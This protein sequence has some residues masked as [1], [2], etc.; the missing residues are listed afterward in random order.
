MERNVRLGAEHLRPVAG[1]PVTDPNHLPK[2]QIWQ[3]LLCTP[4]EGIEFPGRALAEVERVGS[5]VPLT[6]QGFSL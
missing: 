3:L 6:V 1:R 5:M 4:G 2:R